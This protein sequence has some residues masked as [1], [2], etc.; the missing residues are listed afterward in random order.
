M[1]RI[2]GCVFALQFTIAAASAQWPSVHESY[3]ANST[4]YHSK[5]ESLTCELTYKITGGLNVHKQR[6]L[7]ILIYM[8][9]DEDEIM[10]IATTPDYLVKGSQAG[11]QF[12][13]VLLEKKLV[14]NLDSKV[15]TMLDR[16]E[17]K[18]ERGNPLSNDVVHEGKF[19]LSFH[20]FSYSFSFSQSQIL[21]SLSKLPSFEKGKIDDANPYHYG[22]EFGLL[23]FVPVNDS[24]YAEKV[25]ASN[26]RGEW[27]YAKANK[28]IKMGE[29]GGSQV[30]PI[31]YLRSLNYELGFKKYDDGKLSLQIN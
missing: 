5:N 8:R 9:K 1:V 31:L 3:L 26:G 12:L 29:P 14:A 21:E 20:S 4:I 18:D 13:D 16:R 15:A 11:P 17:A 6:Q 30:T 24:K 25:S 7:Y 27:D 22:D 2:V 28:K 19:S 23:A 10:K